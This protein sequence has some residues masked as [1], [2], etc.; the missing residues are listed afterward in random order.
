VNNFESA[1]TVLSARAI[2]A[3]SGGGSDVLHGVSVDLKLGELLAIAGP[4]GAGK[5]TLLKTLSGALKPRSGLVT[6]LGDDL[7]ELDRKT[8]SRRIASVGQESNTAFPFTVLEAVLMGRAPHLAPLRFEG[9]RDLAIARDSMRRFGV[10]RLAG[11][12]I[13]ELS[14]G[15]RKR[16]FLAR[17]LSQQPAVM[18][19]DEPT[20]F[21]DLKHVA[22]IF[23]LFR[24]IRAERGVAI[25]ATLHD[26][27]AA[28]E[29]ADRV[30]LIRGGLS[31]GCGAPP[32]ILTREILQAVYDTDLYVGKNP[33]TGS[34]AIF[35]SRTLQPT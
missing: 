22:S 34:I 32:E 1:K 4:N 21:L 7:A 33:T 2:R 15:E 17:A 8:I 27:N 35:P 3:G 30:M 6:I 13:Q 14:G 20:A 23:G 31:V 16:V 11:R 19:L 29:Y 28:A 12:F 10:E 26:L 9:N 25:I 18:L 5:S 24:E